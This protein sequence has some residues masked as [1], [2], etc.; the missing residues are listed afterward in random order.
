MLAGMPASTVEH[1]FPSTTSDWEWA[2]IRKRPQGTDTV[3]AK[4]GRWR[5]LPR[6]RRTQALTITVAYRGGAEAWWLV[7]ARGSHGVFPGSCAIEDVMA[8]VFN[9]R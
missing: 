2:K 1:P 3:R 9:E 5:H 7:K 8:A 4:R 6:W